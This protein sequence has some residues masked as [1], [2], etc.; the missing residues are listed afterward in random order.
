MHSDMVWPEQHP[1][2]WLQGLSGQWGFFRVKAQVTSSLESL[3]Q[4]CVCSCVTCFRLSGEGLPVLE[5]QGGGCRELL[6][7][8]LV[9]GRLEQCFVLH[10][11][12][13]H[14][15][16]VA[17]LSPASHLTHPERQ[18]GGNCCFLTERTGSVRNHLMGDYLPPT[19]SFHIS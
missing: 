7:Y 18:A 3:K 6:C 12:F 8:C 13:I 9:F 11:T 17:I 2:F 14:F 5:T 19:A 10:I 16:S 15:L 1:R 4:V